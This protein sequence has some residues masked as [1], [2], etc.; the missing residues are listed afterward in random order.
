M[1]PRSGKG[2]LSDLFDT[3]R[4]ERLAESQTKP[5]EVE[6]STG[7]ARGDGLGTWTTDLPKHR[8][9]CPVLAKEIELKAKAEKEKAK[10]QG[11]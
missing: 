1:V 2:L 4:K 3:V 5:K 8:S 11:K 10:T 7:W 9:D 6:G